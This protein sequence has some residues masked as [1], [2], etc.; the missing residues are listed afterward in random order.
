MTDAPTIS[1]PDPE[2]PAKPKRPWT[3]L[4]RLSQAYASVFALALGINNFVSG[5]RRMHRSTTA[6]LKQVEAELD[7]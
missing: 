3:I 1:V 2:P 7:R 5:E 6:L 4:G